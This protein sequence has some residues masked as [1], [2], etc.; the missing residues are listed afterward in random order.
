MCGKFWMDAPENI[1]AGFQNNQTNIV[2]MNSTIPF[3][4]VAE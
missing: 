4:N 1:R 2:R 3:R